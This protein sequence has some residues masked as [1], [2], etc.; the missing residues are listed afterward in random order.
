MKRWAVA[1]IPFFFSLLLS[2][3]TVGGNVFW[4]AGLYA[5]IYVLYYY[6]LAHLLHRMIRAD[7]TRKPGDFT[8]LAVLIGLAWAAHPS[9]ITVGLALILF[10]RAHVPVLGWK[11]LAWRT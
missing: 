11:G 4:Q 8:T 7:E 1:G 6:L 2:A 3:F 9:A 10:V 5:K